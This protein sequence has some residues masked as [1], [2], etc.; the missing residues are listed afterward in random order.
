MNNVPFLCHIY[1]LVLLELVFLGC[2]DIL[3]NS[4]SYFIKVWLTSLQFMK[5]DC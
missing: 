1:T 3:M 2:L 4:I 5:F